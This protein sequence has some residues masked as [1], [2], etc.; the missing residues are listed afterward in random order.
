MDWCKRFPNAAQAELVAQDLFYGKFVRWSGK[1]SEVNPSLSEG[2]IAYLI[3]E[4]VFVATRFSD[5]SYV[6]TLV[7][8]EP[9]I[10]TGRISR[11]CTGVLTLEEGQ[12]S[13]SR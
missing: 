8:G 12:F 5:R 13:P 2:F 7:Q 4:D 6:Q 9:I 1:I 3:V 11:L 10:V